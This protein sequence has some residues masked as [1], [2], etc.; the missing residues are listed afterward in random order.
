MEEL[1]TVEEEPDFFLLGAHEILDKITCA[2]QQYDQAKMTN[3]P[4]KRE[5]CVRHCS[6]EL[7]LVEIEAGCL[8]EMTK[9]ICEID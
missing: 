4:R 8:R 6:Q 5:R 2:I 1:R 3:D 7:Q 9:A